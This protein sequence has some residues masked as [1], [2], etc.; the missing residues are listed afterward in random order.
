MAIQSDTEID[1][2]SMTQHEV[3]KEIGVSRVA[4][5]QIERRAIKKIIAELKKRNI[6]VSDL[7]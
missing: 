7:L 3:A 5:Q 1:K 4:I 6:K 2:Y